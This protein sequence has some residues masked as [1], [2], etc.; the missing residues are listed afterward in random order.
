MTLDTL[1]ALLRCP[2]CDGALAVERIRQRD[3]DAG[4]CGLLRC[5]CTVYPVIDGVPILRRDVAHR[6]IADAL[7]VAEGERIEALVDLVRA[8]DGLEALA[9]L[10]AQP[11]CPWPL[12]RVGALR[13]LS[14]RDPVRSTG[15]AWRRRRVRAMLQR[16]DTLT[17]EDWLSAFYWHAPVPYDPF[18]YFFFRFGQPRHLATLALTSALPP[19]ATPVLDVGCGYGHLL[20]TLTAQGRAGVGLDQ[21]VHQMWL[22]RHYVAP[23]AAFVCAD[24]DAPLPFRDGAF[25]AVVCADAFH[26]IDDKAG[27]FDEMARCSRGAVLLPTVGSANAEPLEGAELSPDG[28]AALFGNRPWCVQTERDLLSRYLDGLGPD[29]SASSSRDHVERD[30][31]LYYAVGDAAMLRAHGPLAEW[32]HAAGDVRV[33]PIY[34]RDGDHLRLDF[35]SPWF[36]FE[37]RGMRAY[38]PDE[39]SLGTA[40]RSDLLGRAILVGL[41]TRYARER[42]P[43]TLSA[44]RS[45]SRFVDRLRR[46]RHQAE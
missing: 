30:K 12:N 38:M 16:R 4:V 28:Y 33:N 10:L 34:A 5:A 1:V 14:V 32:P 22:A 44:N 17:A 29:L 21:N 46:G 26:Y 6:S 45:L 3:E 42:R 40:D 41:P 13:R 24:A 18:N 11:V 2:A 9:R 15:L 36:A 27:A 43:R 8:G 7:V 31:W 25:G 19:A 20:H 35:P 23:G 37:N 39:A